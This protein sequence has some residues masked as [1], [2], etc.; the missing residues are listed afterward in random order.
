MKGNYR[1]KED[2]G[3]GRDGGEKGEGGSFGMMREGFGE[4]EMDGRNVWKW[5]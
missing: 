4:E 1:E 2:E 3:K 5:R